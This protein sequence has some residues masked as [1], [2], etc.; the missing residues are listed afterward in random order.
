MHENSYDIYVNM[1]FI[2]TYLHNC[3][4]LKFHVST[5]AS[6]P[7]WPFPPDRTFHSSGCLI[8]PWGLRFGTCLKNHWWCGHH[9]AQL[10]VI[11]SWELLSLKTNSSP[12]ENNW[13]KPERTA[14]SQQPFFRCYVGF[15]LAL[16]SRWFS[17]RLVGHELV[18]WRV[19]L[20]KDQF[21][22]WRIEKK[23][24]HHSQEN[25]SGNKGF[26]STKPNK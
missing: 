10:K 23:K 15:S 8:R 4:S 22:T 2:I 1:C 19:S 21:I 3:C 11:P 18:P 7:M 14:V 17:S 13:R 20:Y 26:I 5:I 16:F 12:L 6:P 25:G 9:W 24:R